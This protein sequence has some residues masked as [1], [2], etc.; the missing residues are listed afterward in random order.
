M[1]MQATVPL[2]EDPDTDRYPFGPL[3]L[4]GTNTDLYQGGYVFQV[5]TKLGKIATPF[6]FSDLFPVVLGCSCS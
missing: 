5:G 2:C 3:S 6:S 1:L 4:I